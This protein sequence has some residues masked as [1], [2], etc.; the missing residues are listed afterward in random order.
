MARPRQ[1]GERYRCGKLKRLRHAQPS[2]DRGSDYLLS[3]R[4]AMVGADNARDPRAG[5]P[6]GVARLRGIVCQAHLEAGLRYALLSS[7]VWGPGRT[8]ASHL[9][10][11]QPDEP[12]GAE[13]SRWPRDP[14]EY[15]RWRARKEVEW[16]EAVAA[17]RSL[18]NSR[19]FHLL[20]NVIV[21]EHRMRFLDNE[22][23]RTPG[24]FRVDL[25][26]RAALDEALGALAAL[27]GIR[28][29]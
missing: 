8:E 7:I 17:V 4:A 11:L 18:P 14:A 21:Y 22:R 10:K 9:G 27:W 20:E 25:A 19:P 5:Y 26:H 24:A 2:V 15:A 3:H 6:L 12:G 13:Y 23:R 28:C 1:S 29:Q 16:R